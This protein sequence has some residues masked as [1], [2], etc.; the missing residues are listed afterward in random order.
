MGRKK[1][2]DREELLQGAMEIFRESGF[3]GT[4]TQ[5]LVEGL[6]VNRFGLYAEFKNKQNLFDEVLERYN[7]QNVSKNFGPLESPEA[8]INEIVSLFKFFATARKGPVAGRGCLL[9]NTAVEFGEQDPS[10]NQFVQK[11]FKRISQAFS[12]ALSNARD[13]AELRS[14]IRIAEEA[15]FLTSTT[16]GLF[17][18]IRAK[19]PPKV[20]QNAANMAIQRVGNLV[21]NVA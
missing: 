4:S 16:L 11:Y 6:G 10:G 19:A 12:N 2:Y 14:E 18:M 21:S 15:D 7:D 3:A 20:V 13:N 17:V 8:G 1:S 9:C 5:M